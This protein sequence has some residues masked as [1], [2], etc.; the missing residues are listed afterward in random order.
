MM[1]PDWAAEVKRVIDLA[2]DKDPKYLD[3]IDAVVAGHLSATGIKAK[4]GSLDLVI[5]ALAHVT[6]TIH[7]IGSGNVPPISEGGWRDPQR[8]G[9]F[10][11]V[12]PGF[13]SAWKSARGE[14]R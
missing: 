9:G 8:H 1:E 7:G 2:L 10:Y 11:K 6:R 4:Y 14:E 3:V 13:A 12:A 5:S